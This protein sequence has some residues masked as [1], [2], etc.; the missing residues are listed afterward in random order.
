MVVAE[1]K[2]TAEPGLNRVQWDLRTG[3]TD[4]EE[5]RLSPA[6]EYI[7]KLEAGGRTFTRRVRIDGEE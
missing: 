7:V 4:D 1:L 3:K 5:P 2:A 6:G